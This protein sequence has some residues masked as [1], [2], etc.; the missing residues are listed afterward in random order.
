MVYPLR[1]SL[2]KVDNG[3]YARAWGIR[4][5]RV[6][7]D[8]SYSIPTLSEQKLLV[9]TSTPR[10]TIKA[11][12]GTPYGG[13][14]RTIDNN[15]SVYLRGRSISRS[16]RRD[17]GGPFYTETV[18]VSKPREFPIRRETPVYSSFSG[19]QH[20]FVGAAVPMQEFAKWPAS[21]MDGSI[22]FGDL[23][24]PSD[25][26]LKGWG[27]TGISRTIPTKPEMSLSTSIGELKDGL[28]NLIGRQLKR[29]PS[30]HSL[31][32]EYL[33]YQFGIAPM[34]NDVQDVIKLT[35]QYENIVKQFRRDQGRF[36]RRRITLVDE[37]ESSSE[38]LTR[39]TLA[40]AGGGDYPLVSV[41][42][43]PD[44]VRVRKT[45]KTKIWFSG[46][47]T[48]AYPKDADG[49]L[50]EISEFNRV[51]GVLPNAEL[52]WNLLPWSWLVD[53]F[54]NL[55][56]IITNVSYLTSPSTRLA[57]GYVMGEY[58]YS[59]T[60]ESKAG[61]TYAYT[62]GYYG[63][64]WGLESTLEYKRKRRLKASPFGFG[65]DLGGLTGSQAA[66]LSALGLSR[67]KV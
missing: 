4:R 49:L 11:A 7:D 35:K 50:Q 19:H 8:L 58:S 66:I 28:P 43:Q 18:K 32:G 53:W 31:G 29:D 47:Y 2:D 52:A 59:Y 65:V 46:A 61:P 22:Q 64:P 24:P 36:V 54:S 21:I 62:R 6:R 12:D 33:N 20:S 26:T 17:V 10:V 3:F 63:T 51:Y 56:D 60:A 14:Q 9:N 37:E 27:T 34:I 1:E 25:F 57:Y 5:Q 45:H 16:K 67:L 15:N 41:L 13:V 39:Q 40:Y 55:G 48:I 44:G 23:R 30:L 42:A 38:H